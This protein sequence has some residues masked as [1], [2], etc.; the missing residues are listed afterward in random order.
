MAA[1]ISGSTAQQIAADIRRLVD[2]GTLSAGD[3]LPPV[4]QLAD[5]LGV[6]RNTVA[7]A[8]RQLVLAGT[9]VTRGRGGTSIVRPASLPEEG[10]APD[11]VLR[12]VGSGNPARSLLPDLSAVTIP[13]APAVLYGESTLDHGLAEWTTA[14]LSADQPRELRLTVTSGAVDAI[15]RLLAQTLTYGDR[16]ALED[17]CFLASIQTVRLAGYRTEPVPV[18]D[19]GMTVAG[20]TKSLAAG[21]RAVVCTPRAHNPTGVSL[22]ATRA[23]ALRQVLTSHPNVLVIE[24]DHFSL[25]AQAAYHSVIPPQH[26]RWAL[27]RSV[28]KFLGPDLRLAMVASDP[29][30]AAGLA[31]RVSPG[32]LWVSHI[33]QRLTHQLLTDPDAR[34]RLRN[35]SHL[36]SHR[37]TGF[38]QLL[39]ERGVPATSGDGLNVWVDVGHDAQQASEHLMRRGWMV[40]TGNT[41]GLTSG[42]GDRHL[43]LTVHDLDDDS[44]RALADDIAAAALRR[45]ADQA[46][47]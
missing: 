47:P 42:V 38:V 34:Q 29:T 13:A 24:D 3:A 16:V 23:A 8:Y 41:F 37:N 45:Y 20:L 46:L 9:A 25:L 4:R 2:A 43:R 12:D 44:A 36:Y 11:T 40:R 39:A 28:S 6:N 30:T 10:F 27:V 22:T 1:Q 32:T 18:D 17:P 26:R 5:T 35:A 21:V 7:A 19:E 33:L 15:E 14:W 31:T